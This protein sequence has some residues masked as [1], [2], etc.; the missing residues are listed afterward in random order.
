MDKRERERERE[1]KVFREG[2]ER[3]IEEWG[4]RSIKSFLHPGIPSVH[5]ARK[6][7]KC[8]TSL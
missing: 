2:A 1:T 3:Q 6:M 8:F 4:R 5:W 7:P